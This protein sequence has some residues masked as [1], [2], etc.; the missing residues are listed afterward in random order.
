MDKKLNEIIRTS[1][2]S[3][4]IISISLCGIVTI[5]MSTYYIGWVI[6]SGQ[7][8]SHLFKLIFFAIFVVAVLWFL[9]KIVFYSVIATERGL[10]THNIVGQKRFFHWDE[11][12]EIRKPRL[13]I[14]HDVIYVISEDKNKLMLIKGMKNLEELVHLIGSVRVSQMRFLIKTTG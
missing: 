5:L 1:Y 13:G 7:L 14:P 12:V 3:W 8:Y 2:P 11:I 4:F 9:L 6:S 10:E